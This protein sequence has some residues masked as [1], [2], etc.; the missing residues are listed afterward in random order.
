M[1]QLAAMSGVTTVARWEELSN[2]EGNASHNRSLRT[3]QGLNDAG[4]LD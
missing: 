1:N 2:S 4:V 3:K